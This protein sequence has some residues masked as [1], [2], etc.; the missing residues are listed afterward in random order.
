M[1]SSAYNKMLD[2]MTREEPATSPGSDYTTNFNSHAPMIIY[3]A[4]STTITASKSGSAYMIIR[5]SDK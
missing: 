5:I 3:E 1:R 4:T 2:F